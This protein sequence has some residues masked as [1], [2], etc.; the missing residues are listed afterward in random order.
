MTK[1]DFMQWSF[2]YCSPGLI[3]LELVIFSLSFSQIYFDF[4]NPLTIL[5]Q[6]YLSVAD[7]R[8]YNFSNSLITIL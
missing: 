2:A 4:F 5:A 1:P 6:I 3:F 7:V 8:S